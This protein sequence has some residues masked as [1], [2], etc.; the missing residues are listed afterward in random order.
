MLDRIKKAFNNSVDGLLVAYDQERSFREDI[1][2]FALFFP[3][4]LFSDVSNLEKAVLIFSLFL[5]LIAELANTAIEI[6]IDRISKDNHPLSKNAKD[7]GSALVF[8]ALANAAAVW[9]LIFFI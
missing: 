4:A 9:T 1:V 3:L 2:I 6:T 7:V 8:L 5:I